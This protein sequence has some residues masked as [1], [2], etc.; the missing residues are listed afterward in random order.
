MAQVLDR[1]ELNG[2]VA[3]VTGGA[4]LLG[5][6]FSRTLAEAGAAVI[7]AD[8]N[9]EQAKKVAEGLAGKVIAR[10]VDVTRPDSV[11][12]MIAAAR[13]NYGRLDILVCGAALDP[14]FDSH[15][16]GTYEENFENYP[17]EK[18]RA[19]LDV[20][21]TGVFLSA[22]AAAPLMLE[23]GGGVMVL[24][25]S[26]YGLAGPDQRIYQNAQS[27]KQY[28]PPDYAVAKTGLLGLTRYLA[29]Y[30]AGKNIRVNAL[31][32]GGIYN[33][34]EEAFVQSYSART[35]LGRMADR[36]EMNAAL[37]FLASDASSYMTGSNLVVDGGWTSW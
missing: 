5:T 37:L 1:F 24:I 7:V 20:N 27:K 17:L 36:E 26:I 22:Q 23:G 21:L 33:D 14:K 18:W 29:A 3:V 13:R 31:S 16:T 34:H 15:Q 10:E 12:A 4:G 8:R 19:A 2:R 32:P 6:G 35:I 11:R 28:K 30:F 9:V 25:S